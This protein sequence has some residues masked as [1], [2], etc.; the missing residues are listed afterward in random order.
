MLVHGR[1]MQHAT[2]QMLLWLIFFRALQDNEPGVYQTIT[3]LT[4]SEAR[5]ETA[6]C[7]CVNERV[8]LTLIC[9]SRAANVN[10]N[11]QAREE[12]KWFEV[13]VCLRQTLEKNGIKWQQFRVT[14]LTSPLLRPALHSSYSPLSC[15]SFPSS[16]LRHPSFSH[17][18]LVHMFYIKFPL[19][20]IGS[21]VQV[22][23]TLIIS[24]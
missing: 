1:D 11:G 19:L 21:S 23:K 5:H 8:A 16:D 22:I 6:L 3:L 24:E 15:S 18:S 2:G 4:I 9:V 10:T 12:C 7:L 20:F 14:H 13:T 17:V